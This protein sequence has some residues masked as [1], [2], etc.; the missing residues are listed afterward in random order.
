MKNWW[1][2]LFIMCSKS[3]FL[4]SRKSE[5]V[6]RC[7]AVFINVELQRE[8][9]SFFQK[10]KTTFTSRRKIRMNFWRNC[11]KWIVI[12]LLK[13]SE[14]SWWLLVESGW[15]LTFKRQTFNFAKLQPDLSGNPF[16]LLL[17]FYWTGKFL[18]K[19]L[20]AEGGKAAQIKFN[21]NH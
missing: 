17:S 12:S 14:N 5:L 21:Y 1:L 13:M 10:I 11:W 4:K 8:V 19:R 2:A 18:Q 16:L 3:I 9:S 20:G 7:G 6:K 15:K